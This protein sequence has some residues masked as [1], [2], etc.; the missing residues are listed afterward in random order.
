LEEM[1]ANVQAFEAI[2]RSALSG[3][4]ERLEG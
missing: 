4:I 1:T 2:T 3:R